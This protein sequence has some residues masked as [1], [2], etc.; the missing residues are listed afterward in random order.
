MIANRR[1]PC[2]VRASRAGDALGNGY[3]DRLKRR[4]RER[5]VERDR[6]AVQSIANQKQV[7]AE[8]LVPVRRGDPGVPPDPISSPI[9]NALRRNENQVPRLNRVD[10]RAR[11]DPP[12][13]GV[14][15]DKRYGQLVASGEFQRRKFQP[16]REPVFPR[17]VRQRRD[18]GR[19]DALI[20]CNRGT[21]SGA[22]RSPWRGEKPLQMLTHGVDVEAPPDLKTFV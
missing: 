7:K 17:S 19:I 5:F 15:R 20:R 2:C 10:F 1:L 4:R 18:I 14:R 21:K 13:R 9:D 16:R 12:Q 3:I 22:E 11:P 8:S 6:A